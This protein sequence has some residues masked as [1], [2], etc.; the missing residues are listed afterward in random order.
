MSNELTTINSLNQ[1]SPPTSIDL[2]FGYYL[3]EVYLNDRV[4]HDIQR[5][6]EYQQGTES[7][8]KEHERCIK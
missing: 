2:E 6:M 1:H 5:M 7:K 4:E 8:T 3:F